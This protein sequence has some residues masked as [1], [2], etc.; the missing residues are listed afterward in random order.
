MNEARN[1]RNELKSTDWLCFADIW[2]HT[3]YQ[4]GEPIQICVN[5]WD[6]C[7]H[8]LESFESE[9]MGDLRDSGC[10]KG[11]PTEED[12]SVKIVFDREDGNGEECPV[13]YPIEISLREAVND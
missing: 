12:I 2:I 5:R 3:H 11:L 13:F 9:D 8:L 6:G 7:R 1:E 10:L 4:T